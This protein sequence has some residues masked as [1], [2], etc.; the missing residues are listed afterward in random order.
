MAMMFDTTFERL[1]SVLIVCLGGTDFPLCSA[2]RDM[3]TQGLWSER[4]FGS[5]VL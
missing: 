2:L 3:G 1:T 4:F 5:T